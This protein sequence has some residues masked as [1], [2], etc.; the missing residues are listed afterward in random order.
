MQS[1]KDE[2]IAIIYAIVVAPFV[3]GRQLFYKKQAFDESLVVEYEAINGKGSLW[4][5]GQTTPLHGESEQ[6][7]I[8][9]RYAQNIAGIFAAVEARKNAKII[10]QNFTSQF[11]KA[12]LISGSVIAASV[13]FAPAKIG[14][15]VAPII[16][17]VLFGAILAFANFSYNNLLKGVLPGIAKHGEKEAARALAETLIRTSAIDA[18]EDLQDLY[19]L[20]FVDALGNPLSE[21]LYE[22]DLTQDYFTDDIFKT[23][24]KLKTKLFHSVL[25]WS[26]IGMIGIFSIGILLSIAGYMPGDV[27]EKV[28]GNIIVAISIQAF[29]LLWAAAWLYDK[30]TS[31]SLDRRAVNLAAI[32]EKSIDQIAQQSGV[33]ATLVQ[34]DKAREA[35]NSNAKAD[36]TPFFELGKSAG[37]L[38]DR[39]DPFAPSISGM[40]VGLSFNDLSTHLIV[41]GGTGS[42]KTSGTIRPLVQQWLGSDEGGLLVLDGKGQLPAEI[43]ADDY[44]LIT[45]EKEDLNP[46]EGLTPD[47]VA[48][49]LSNLAGEGGANADPYWT[50]AAAKLIRSSAH[51]AQVLSNKGE[52]FYN[53]STIYEISSNSAAQE[54]ARKN[55]TDD[56]LQKLS[57]AA[58]RGVRYALIEFPV[59]PEKQRG[60]IEGIAG[61][62]LSQITDNDKLSGWADAVTGY[63]I[64]SV[65]RGARVGVLLPES[66]YGKAGVLVSGLLKKRVYEAI[67]RRGDQWRAADGETPV[68]VVIDEVQEILT[69]DEVNMLPIAR[70]LGL[71]A[72]FSTQNVDGILN[73][74]GD[75]AGYQL[76]GNLRSMVAYQTQTETTMQYISERMGSSFRP[77]IQ[78]T[79]CYEDL[80]SRLGKTVRLLRNTEKSGSD[81]MQYANGI[82]ALTSTVG[83]RIASLP[84][85]VVNFVM[86][87]QSRK[88]MQ[89]TSSDGQTLDAEAFT[90]NQ[91]IQSAEHIERWGLMAQSL[92]LT[93]N[94]EAGEVNEALSEPNTAFV[95][96][97]R[98]RVTRRDLVNTN[99]IFN[100]SAALSGDQENEQ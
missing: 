100:M 32:S 34:E 76:L 18:P 98:G 92:A 29:F 38:R 63:K 75:H 99:P 70:S 28:S 25:F 49:T 44:R 12:G 3:F 37:F 48:E 11:R 47:D 93:K 81:G 6:H 45:P 39:F 8:A 82:G 72:A 62:W 46:I 41:L 30:S 1:T 61:L 7:F 71:Y 95:Q 56:V 9:R 74:L 2:N 89:E 42:G 90:H 86:N 14:L 52:G 83:A 20:P 68:L 23:T 50:N 55:I 15:I 97:I 73:R 94:V 67:K 31:S 10:Q 22:P 80:N 66:I 57:G 88:R 40:P 65:T 96:V 4:F 79:E 26:V 91:N 27:V 59:L 36:K 77:T 58:R 78:Q 43:S 17:L 13:I 54:D 5:S 21:R 84:S 60:S 87:P 16:G 53:L 51:V 35:Q 19:R 64:E 85:S 24:V 69:D 33:K